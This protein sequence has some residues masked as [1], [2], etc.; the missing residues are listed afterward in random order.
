[1]WNNPGHLHL[2]S[3]VSVRVT[4]RHSQLDRPFVQVAVRRAAAK[5]ERE[6]EEQKKICNKYNTPSRIAFPH[7][8]SCHLISNLEIRKKTTKIDLLSNTMGSGEHK[9][10]RNEDTGAI[11]NLLGSSQNRRN[12]W[13]IARL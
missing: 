1:M 4:T 12:K 6:R 2:L 8:R 3:V 10:V 11:K 7:P 5:G 9:L 13:P